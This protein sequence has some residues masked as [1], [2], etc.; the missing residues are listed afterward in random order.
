MNGPPRDEDLVPFV[1]NNVDPLNPTVRK[2]RQAWT[3]IVRSGPELGK[4]NVIARESYVQW[5]KE[6]AQVVK[7]P[8][9]FES[10]SLPQ[11]PKPEPILQE[12]VDKLTSK[13]NELELENTRF[14]LQLI[15]EK[16]RGDDL[17]DEGKE[18]ATAA[19]NHVLPLGNPLVQ[20]HVGS[21]EGTPPLGGG[22]PVN[23]NPIVPPGFEV[24]NHN[25]AFYNPREDSVYDAFRPTRRDVLVHRESPLTRG[26]FPNSNDSSQR[27]VVILVAQIQLGCSGRSK[28]CSI[29]FM[30]SMR[31]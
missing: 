27:M 26:S 17:E 23:Q 4:K 1:I 9:Y 7:M 13:I 3:K 28:D 24:D 14:R 2:V 29:I 10:L 16:Q 12:D 30:L 5:A 11:A 18:R 22:G 31:P 6:R 21:L 19:T 20:I 8:F 15:R 25:D